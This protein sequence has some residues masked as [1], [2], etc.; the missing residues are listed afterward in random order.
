MISL[1]YIIYFLDN[2]FIWL[3]DYWV[4]FRSPS[5]KAASKLIKK[6]KSLWML[7]IHY[8]SHK[9]LQPLARIR[10][11]KSAPY[12]REAHFIFTSS[13][14][15]FSKQFLPFRLS[16]KNVQIAHLSHATCSACPILTGLISTGTPKWSPRIWYL[17]LAGY[18]LL[19][20][21]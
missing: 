15:I 3:H 1:S 20:R 19:P 12:F 10:H 6:F 13:T 14:P 17:S 9:S 7:K 21:N 18:L 11:T 8:C 2:M 4:I 5:W 16:D